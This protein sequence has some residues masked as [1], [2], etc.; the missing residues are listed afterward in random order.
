MYDKK[1][2][3]LIIFLNIEEKYKSI[4]KLDEMNII[5]K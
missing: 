1:E 4:M 2:K 5:K 3:N